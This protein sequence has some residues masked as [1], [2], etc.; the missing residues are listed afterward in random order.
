MRV[1]TCTCLLIALVVSSVA[2]AADTPAT[3]PATQPTGAD[4]PN[5]R[6]PLGNWTSPEKGLLRQW[7][8]EGPKVLWRA[9]IGQ[10]WSCPSIVGKEVYVFSTVWAT[11]GWENSDK[12][13]LVCL[14][15]SSGK[16][17]WSYEYEIGG[18]YQQK[19]IGW[20]WGG[21]RATPTVTDKYVYTLGSIGRLTCLDRKTHKKVWDNDLNKTYW[22][23]PY[24]EWKGTNFSPMVAG[25]VVLVPFYNAGKSRCAA[26]DAETGKLKW[27]YPDDEDSKSAKGCSPGATPAI[28]TIG[29]EPCAILPAEGSLS[30]RAIRLSDGKS[31]WDV[32]TKAS[33]GRPVN[34]P[35]FF[36]DKQ[37]VML[38]SP[39]VNL[40]VTDVDFESPTPTGK[41]AYFQRLGVG[42]PYHEL[43]PSGD[44]FYGMLE[45]SGD[46]GKPLDTWS[47]R[48]VCVDRKT[49]QVSWKQEGFKSGV[50]LI[51]ADGLLFVQSFQSLFLIEASPKGYVEKGKVEKLHDVTNKRGEDGG[52]VVPALSGGKLFVRTPAELICFQVK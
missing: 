26:L 52:W 19:N 39:W 27:A 21:V 42:N 48:L 15:A 33:D 37:L 8:T 12:E 16:E 32:Q 28:V 46:T 6:G 49:G 41:T 18:H 23:G 2:R 31:V 20:N 30:M 17:L 44:A 51:A 47:Y 1:A 14:D 3:A 24:P 45:T 50:S 5:W 7:P 34:G 11:G 35:F 22:P 43:V 25:G 36:S 10:G 9:K 40:W 29:K 38:T 13:K 4:W